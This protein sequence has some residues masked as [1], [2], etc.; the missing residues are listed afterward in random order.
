MDEL[1]RTVLWVSSRGRQRPVCVVGQ[2]PSG[3]PPSLSDGDRLLV[4]TGYVFVRY[5]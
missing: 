4:N 5:Y 2:E 3:L 1:E